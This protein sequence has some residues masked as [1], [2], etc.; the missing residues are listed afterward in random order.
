MST[1]TVS[2]ADRRAKVAHRSPRDERPGVGRVR[3]PG[4][5]H[6][7]HGAVILLLFTWMLPWE[8][9]LGSVRLT[10]Y[11]L[12]LIVLLLP[13]LMWFAA[14]RAG[15][16]RL[17]DVLLLGFALWCMLS[18]GVVHGIST[19]FQT[20]GIQFLE[21]LTPYLIAR[22]CIRNADDF[23]ALA[24]LLTWIVLALLPFAV[25]E[26]VTGRNI[27]LE[28]MSQ[29]FSTIEL[30]H[31]DPRWGL[32]R[33]QLFFEHPILM[34]VCLGSILTLTHLV[35][36][37]EFY[38]GRRWMRSTMVGLTAALS[39]SSGPLSGMMVQII[40]M[41]WNWFFSKIKGRWTILISLVLMFILAV[42]LFARRPLP[43]I[44]VSFAF[45]QESGYYRILIWNYGSESVARHPWFG[46]GL[47]S[48]DRPA[49]MPPSID[50]FW[51]YNAIVF[52]LP[53]GVLMMAFFAV[54]VWSIGKVRNLDQRLYDYRAAYLI[55]MTSF[56]LTGWMV[57][58][59]NG[60]YVFFLFMV[61]AGMWLLNVPR[62]DDG[63]KLEPEERAMAS[64]SRR[65]LRAPRQPVGH[66]ER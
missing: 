3:E 18:L 32:R 11:R 20:G 15:R 6:R 46:V 59:W 50:M 17:P 16:V 66:R 27:Y 29:F 54:T 36:G 52:G 28:I 23:R 51:L 21:T 34:G 48:W 26:A 62:Q 65:P 57:H 4:N 35:V 43:N 45:E 41:G 55:A 14:G 44:L 47:G 13:S 1:L 10:P 58:F 40:L 53:G 49:W 12:S 37:R 24:R 19:A 56:F 39:L 33:V 64:R 38:F 30:A 5:S 22:C 63:L 31:K 25:F 42:Q 7:L 2:R 8:Y 60:T 61:G 9:F